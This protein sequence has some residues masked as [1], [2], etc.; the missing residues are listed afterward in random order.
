MVATAGQLS[1]PAKLLAGR[2]QKHA[3]PEASRLRSEREG[4]DHER[5]QASSPAS[6]A[7]TR[8]HDGHFVAMHT[9][10]PPMSFVQRYPLGQR[11]PVSQGRLQ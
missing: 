9:D 7:A 6:A 11:L 3:A 1:R 2:S 10:S 4:E 8:R 5:D